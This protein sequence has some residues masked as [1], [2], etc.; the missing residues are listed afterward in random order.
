[1]P[2]QGRP[3]QKGQSGNPSGRPK[4]D[5]SITELARAHGP[6]AIQ[7]LAELMNDPKATASAR[8]MAADRILD[9]AYGRP[10]QLNTTDAGQFRRACDMT[11]DELAAIIARAQPAPTVTVEPEAEPLPPDPKKVN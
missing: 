4:L 9:R 7:V 6:R 3:F 11:D 8:A 1:M 2:G 5:Q 10:P